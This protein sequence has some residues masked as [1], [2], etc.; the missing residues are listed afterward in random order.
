MSPSPTVHFFAGPSLSPASSALLTSTPGVHLRPPVRRG[1]LPA[2]VQTSGPRPVVVLVDG[3]FFQSMAV[4]PREVLDLLS[5]GARVAGAA[6]MGALRAAE[7][8][9]YGMV[10]IGRVVALYRSR[11]IWADDEVALAVEPECQRALTVSLVSV[12]CALEQLVT[13]GEVPMGGAVETLAFVR[14]LHFTQRTLRTITIAGPDRTVGAALSRHLSEPLNDVKSVD[15]LA[16]A[17]WAAAMTR[18]TP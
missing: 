16:A 5:T 3:E 18:G 8:A 4:T 1:D 14:S 9:P 12:R 10:G 2:L 6:S 11:A 13:E 17:R 7:L 15:T